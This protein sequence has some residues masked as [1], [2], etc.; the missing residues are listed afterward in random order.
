LVIG[1]SAIN[2]QQTL[3]S[4]TTYYMSNKLCS[5]L[6]ATCVIDADVSASFFRC[7]LYL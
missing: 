5:H 7:D 4:E 2:F 6:Q 1:T 3:I